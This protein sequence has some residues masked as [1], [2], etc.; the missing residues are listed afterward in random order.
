MSDWASCCS[1]WT[2]PWS[3][4]S[5]HRAGLDLPV[6]IGGADR[7]RRCAAG[8]GAG[9]GVG[10][11]SSSCW[12]S[13]TTRRCAGSTSRR[14][15]CAGGDLRQRAVGR[16]WWP[17]RSQQG[18]RWWPWSR[19]PAGSGCISWS[20]TCWSITGTART[21]RMT[22]APICSV[23]RSRWPTAST[24]WSASK[25]PSRMCWPIRPPTTKPTSCGGCP[26]WAAPARPS[27]WSGSANG[28]FSTR[29][30]PAARW[31]A[32]PS[33]RNWACARGWRSGFISRR[34]GHGGRRC[35]PAPSGCSRARS[36]WPTTPRRCCGA[37]QCWPPGSCRGWRRVRPRMRDGCSNCS[38]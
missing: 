6:A 21:R 25:T 1:R 30:A 5:R 16:A 27:I 12:V 23:W 8:P 35:S 10:R 31:C 32:S 34:P 26:S 15:A 13:P 28:A 22:R 14:A 24:A 7:L 19:R 29:C 3:A 4:W 9:R 33:G 18:Q 38:V 2:R 36:H 37:R 11:S 17:R 20:I